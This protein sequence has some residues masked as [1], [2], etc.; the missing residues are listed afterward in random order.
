MKL[1]E[2]KAAKKKEEILRSASKIISRRGYE[3]AT[4]EDIA[5]ELLMTKGALYYYFASKEELLYECHT[6]ILSEASKK[7]EDIYE[8]ETSS[9]EKMKRAITFHIEIAITEKETFNMIIKP[10]LTFSDEHIS[11]ILKQRDEY[12][13]IFDKIIQQGMERGEFTV[14][15]KKMARMIILGAMNWIQQWY[16]PKGDKNK[17]EIAN[18]YADYL[19][20][21]LT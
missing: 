19:L 18:A 15:E 17:D 7:L 5:A 13:G 4:M 12:A 1:R 3:G 10:G 14:Q 2:K 11:M 21:M 6:L 20:K 16:S 9:I 8:A